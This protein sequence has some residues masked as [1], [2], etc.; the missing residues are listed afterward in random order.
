MKK[1]LEDIVVL[2]LGQIYNGPYCSL[3][4]AFQGAKVIKIEPL[5]GE[6]LRVRRKGD[7]HEL[8]ML[9]SNKKSVSIDLKSEEGKEL[10]LNLVKKADVLVENFSLGAMDRLGL[11]YE[12]LKEVNPSLIYASGKGYGLE[13]PYAERLAMDLTIQAMGGVMATT[14]FADKPPVKAGPALCD[15]L[16]GIHLFGGITTAL[17]QREKTGKGQ[18]IE[19]SMHDTIYPTLASALGAYYSSGGKVS[20]RTG[21]QHSG[22]AT[23]PYNV[24]AASDGYIAILCVADRQWQSLLK[25]IDKHDLLEDERFQTNIDRSA[26]TELVDE[27]VTNWT[28]DKKKLEIS[29]ILIEANVP[30]APVLSIDEVADDPHLKYRKMIREIEHPQAGNIKVPGSPIRLSDSTLEEVIAAPLLGQHTD[31]VLQDMLG[32]SHDQ[33]ESLHQKKVILTK[34]KA[35]Q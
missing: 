22:M 21:N 1:A 25:V 11:G 12:V 3:M 30:H 32:L 8:L 6:N 19:V 17:Y 23:A 14:G 4:L 16:G 31:E 29:D 10:F 35:V 34:E 24:Y 27:I 28:F 5:K 7:S 20:Q 15:F 18:L 9:N 33:L 26:H 13:G 2:D